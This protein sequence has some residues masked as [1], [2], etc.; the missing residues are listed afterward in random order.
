L[1]G[2]PRSRGGAA[3][4]AEDAREMNGGGAEDACTMNEGGA[5]DACTMNEGG[6]EDARSVN[7]PRG[8]GCLC[9]TTLGVV[10]LCG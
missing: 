4:G 6:A 5:E 1:C 3:A 7:G 8:K 2:V 9:H 10:S